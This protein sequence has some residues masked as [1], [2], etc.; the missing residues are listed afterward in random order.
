MALQG[1]VYGPRMLEAKIFDGVAP[2]LNRCRRD[3]IP[4]VII[5]HKTQF[6]H[7]DPTATDLRLAALEWMRRQGFFL[8]TGFGLAPGAVSFA[9]TREEKVALIAEAGCDIFIDDLEEV[10]TH[11]AFPGGCRRLHLAQDEETSAAGLLHCRHW[12]DVYDAV[13]SGRD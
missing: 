7:F 10:L 8:A 4:V 11:P 5:S 9:A 6:G 13:F 2:F 1:E 3:A 12:P